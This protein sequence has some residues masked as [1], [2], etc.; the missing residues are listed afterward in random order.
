[1]GVRSLSAEEAEFLKKEKPEIKTYY[2]ADIIK[3]RCSDEIVEELSEEVFVTIDLD[4][5]DP[6]IMP[7]TG[8][9]EPGGLGWYEVLGL[10]RS[11]SLRRKVVGFDV[12]ELCP[13]PGYLAP[14][15]LAARLTY[16]LMGY[17]NEGLE[18]RK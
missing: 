12:V 4:V 14:D 16:K 15:F 6:S 11:V 8:T 10:L 18:A 3:G 2:A 5:F 7:A 13:I 1:V 17:I 9:P